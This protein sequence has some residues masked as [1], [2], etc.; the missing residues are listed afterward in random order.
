MSLCKGGIHSSYRELSTELKYSQYLQNNR[1][2]QMSQSSLLTGCVHI[3]SI[4]SLGQAN[5]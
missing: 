3:S 2:N 1:L 4:L 5:H